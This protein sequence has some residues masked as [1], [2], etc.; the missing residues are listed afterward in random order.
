MSVAY[1]GS[2]R[3]LEPLWA[4]PVV[5]G[6]V[7]ASVSAWDTPLAVGL[8]LVALVPWALEYVG[9]PLPEWLF[10]VLAVVPVVAVVVL[11]DLNAAVF[12]VTS[13]LCQLVARRAD[14][15]RIAVAAVLGV[16]VPSTPVLA[17]WPFNEGAVYFAIGDL[18][19][20]VV[21]VLLAHTRAL[22]AEL[23]AA[24][25]RLATARAQEERT[26][27][28]RDVH[29]LVA[30]SLTVV[31]LQIGGAR[32]ILRS[33]VLAAEEALS[34]AELV[35]RESLDGVRDVVGLL[36]TDGDEPV[37]SWSLEHLR[38]TYRTAGVEVRLD[39]SAD[40]EAVP[41]L[42]RGTVFRVVQEALANAARYRSPGSAVDVRVTRES[43]VL[44]GVVTNVLPTPD[45]GA[46]APRRSAG[47]YG[48]PGLREQVERA[49][50]RIDSGPDG[51]RWLV[52]F[53]LP[54]DVT[55]SVAAAR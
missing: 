22:A 47:G 37:R 36:R 43:G 50:G 1:P 45:G 29:D 48:L 23:R 25:A 12:L 7:A 24:D 51:D 16:V 21:G 20:I 6:A 32:R 52:A 2:P 31:V 34:Q 19:A 14:R 10:A 41:L 53:R 54:T 49:G 26:R 42:A 55:R 27:L 35:C 39:V 4:V 46:S 11:V 8:V 38:D 5:L 13:A 44:Q 9:R 17:G 28:A 3:R 40:L 33:D 15:W 30:H 18:L